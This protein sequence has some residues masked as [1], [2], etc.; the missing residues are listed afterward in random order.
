MDDQD[1]G[2]RLSEEGAQMMA[3]VLNKAIKLGLITKQSITN[4]N[5]K[6]YIHTLADHDE[7]WEGTNM[8]DR[9]ERKVML[10]IVLPALIAP[11]ATETKIEYN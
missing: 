2:F 7:I 10:A 3:N 9:M 4:S 8:E 11:K 5:L 6:D 1:D